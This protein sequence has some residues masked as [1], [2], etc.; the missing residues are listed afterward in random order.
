M[1]V[2]CLNCLDNTECVCPLGRIEE[3]NEVSIGADNLLGPNGN[4]FSL[5]CRTVKWTSLLLLKALGCM[6]RFSKHFLVVPF[7]FPTENLKDQLILR[8]MIGK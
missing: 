2:G 7:A 1:F 4:V 6:T 8:S 3:K 5:V